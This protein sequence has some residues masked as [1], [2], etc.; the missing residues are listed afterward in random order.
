MLEIFF[1][2]DKLAR[3]SATDRKIISDLFVSIDATYKYHTEMNPV[4][5]LPLEIS[6]LITNWRLV[7]E[8]LKVKFDTDIDKAIKIM[9][10]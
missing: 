7:K 5:N 1:I 10:G 3:I 2:L 8:I 6:E 4:S 9:K